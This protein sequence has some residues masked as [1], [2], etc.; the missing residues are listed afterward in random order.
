M[1][2]YIFYPGLDVRQ[3]QPNWNA[4]F[5]MMF[6]NDTILFRP[7]T[8]AINRLIDGTQENLVPGDSTTPTG[9][10]AVTNPNNCQANFVAPTA[11]GAMGPRSSRCRAGRGV[12][13]AESGRVAGALPDD[14]DRAHVHGRATL[15]HDGDR[16]Q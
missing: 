2:V 6:K 12:H 7:Y 4:D 11:A 10:F 16:Y 9:F 13:R 3:N 5:K 15:L 1:P 14:D 8:A